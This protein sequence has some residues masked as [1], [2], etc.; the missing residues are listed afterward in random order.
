M[1]EDIHP[2]ITHA[3]AALGGMSL[4][5]VAARLFALRGINLLL[6]TA[7]GKAAIKAVADGKV[8]DAELRQLFNLAGDALHRKD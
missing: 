1:I 6:G 8:D 2:A 5:G 7:L 4:I 3:V